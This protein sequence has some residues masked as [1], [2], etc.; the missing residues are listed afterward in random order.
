[1]MQIVG[2]EHYNDVKSFGV[3]H[4][5]VKA[6]LLLDKKQYLSHQATR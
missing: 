6:L 4:A 3:E 2:G 1:M 5:L